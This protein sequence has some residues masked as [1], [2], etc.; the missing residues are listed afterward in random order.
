VT[1]LEALVLALPPALVHATATAMTLAESAAFVG[2]LLPG[3]TV[4]FL[5]GVLAGL[6]VVA[7][8]P[9]ALL[10]VGGAVL[11]DA[12]GF[13]LG[14]RWGPA[15]R[16]SRLGRRVGEPRW[17]RTLVPMTAGMS[18]LGFGRFVLADVAGATAWVG[19]VVG[20]GYLAAASWSTALPLLAWAGPVVLVTAGAWFAA[21]G[22]LRRRSSRR[23][24]RATA[25]V[26]RRWAP[27]VPPLPGAVAPRP[28]IG[29]TA[30]PGRALGRRPVAVLVLATCLLATGCDATTAA[31]RPAPGSLPQRAGPVTSPGCGEATG[32]VRHVEFDSSSFG[33]VGDFQIYLPPCYDT[34]PARRY[35][36][37]YLLHGAG[38]DDQYWLEVGADRAAD[39]E[40]A[41]GR[42][43]PVILVLPDGGVRFEG[44]GEQVPFERFLS[45]ELVPRVDGGWRTRA[46][47]AHRAIGGISLG[48]AQAL[49]AAADLPR[50]FTAV[51]GH[52]AVIH[53]AAR[54]AD[55]F[56]RDGTAVYLDVGSEDSLRHS[57]EELS[58]ALDA[59]DVQHVF[60]V[61]PG[62]HVE[63]YWRAWVPEYLRFY[64][65]ALSAG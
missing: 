52:S 7:P 5:T 3:E 19:V 24:R 49:E 21:R 36:V 46:D 6:H 23:S 10:A 54:L 22:L 29:S 61:S 16:G 53:D 33:E 28:A 47:R 41:A 45:D 8:L 48:G 56:A 35:P 55:A 13:A 40:I 65:A 60:R 4:L 63:D 12:A 62:R 26:D 30:R 32:R 25:P 58:A 51:G 14:R 44:A 20:L 39:A 59:R 31:P 43:D 15:L 38:H 64:D 57:D 17:A 42:I 2:L 11:G 50:L 1:G 37:V 9:L 27:A 18:G 34:D